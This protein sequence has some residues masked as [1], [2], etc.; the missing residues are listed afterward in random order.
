MGQIARQL[1]D[2][3]KEAAND[4]MI[5][6]PFLDAMQSAE[7]THAQWQDFA[8]Q[9]YL[10]ALP[11]EKLLVAA[12]AASNA[13]NDAE[14]VAALEANL[15]DELGYGADGVQRAELAHETW[16]QDFYRALGISPQQLKQAQPWPGTLA[17]QGAFERLMATHDALA[18]AGGLLVLEGTIPYEYR[19]VQAGR[20]QTF[21]AVFV[22]NATDDAQTLAQ[23]A[24]ARLYIDDHIDHD[25]KAHYPDLLNAL[26]KYH[27]DPAAMQRIEMGANLIREGKNQFYQELSTRLINERERLPTQTQTTY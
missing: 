11:F 19:R 14:L 24:L 18:M 13:L 21:A 25:A 20:N 1:V 10:A 6:N 27:L 7:L 8:M 4:V 26:S 15:R 3:I 9:R 17:F 12:I 22:D 23:K 2:Y 5:R 16:R